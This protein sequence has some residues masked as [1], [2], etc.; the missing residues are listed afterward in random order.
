MTPDETSTALAFE[1]DNVFVT[2]ML[3]QT[4]DG[5]L[6]TTKTQAF[7]KNGISLFVKKTM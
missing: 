5:N 7:N 1:I 2:K 3:K 6:I 4:D